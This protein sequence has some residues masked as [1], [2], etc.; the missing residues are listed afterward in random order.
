MSYRLLESS[1]VIGRAVR[2]CCHVNQSTP[3]IHWCLGSTRSHQTAA[4]WD[5][6]SGYVTGKR[7]SVAQ[8]KPTAP[9]AINKHTHTHTVSC[10]HGLASRSWNTLTWPPEVQFFLTLTSNS[11]SNCWNKTR[12]ITGSDLSEVQ[13]NWWMDNPKNIPKYSVVFQCFCT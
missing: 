3:S 13:V 5:G 8:T 2:A 10:W 4:F 11:W 6:R 7:R 1:K 9:A 12:V